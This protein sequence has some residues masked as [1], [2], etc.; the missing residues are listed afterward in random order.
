MEGPLNPGDV[1]IVN[2]PYTDDAE[3]YKPRPA[4]VLASPNPFICILAEITTS[5]LLRPHS[6]PLFAQDFV[7]GRIRET[8]RIRADVIFTLDI[9][10]FKEKVGSVSEAKLS[11]VLMALSEILYGRI[12]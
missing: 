10:M 12:N 3:K 1:V 9:K 5:L 7:E 6:V 8:S 11:E 4:L 2:F